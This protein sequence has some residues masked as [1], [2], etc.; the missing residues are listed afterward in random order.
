MMY[1][2]KSLVICSLMVASSIASPKVP[3]T[4]AEELMS[5]SFASQLGL[6]QAWRRQLHVTNGASAIADFQ[7][8]IS[9]SN[10]RKSV[11]VVEVGAEGQDPKVWFSIATDQI[12]KSGQPIGE[13]EAQRLARRQ[14]TFLTR[15]VKNELKIESKETPRVYLYTLASNGTVDCRDAESGKPIWISQV[16]DPELNYGQLGVDDQ[17]VTVL[18]GSSIILLDASNGEPIDSKRT[19]DVPLYGTVISGGFVLAPT[20]RNGVEGY[21]LADLNKKIT[22]VRYMQTVEGLSLEPLA[23]SPTSPVVAWGT[24]KGYIY[25]MDV[26]NAP[27]VTF[28]LDTVGN[29]NGK[30]APAGGDRFFF[31]SEGGQAYSVRATRLG[32]VLWSQPL[33]EPFYDTP[34][35]LE[36]TVF[37][38]S[39][40][41]NLFALNERTG[42]P[43]WAEPTS[44]VAKILGGIPGALF[45]RLMSGQF[46]EIDAKTG[47]VMSVLPIDKSE[48]LAVNR[49]TDRLY[50]IDGR[51]VAQCL[52][53]VGSTAPAILHP[54]DAEPVV[55]EEAESTEKPEEAMPTETTPTDPFGTGGDPFGTGGADPFGTGGGS[56][57]FGTSG[58]GDPFGGDPFGN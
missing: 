4:S 49:L 26:T 30:P 18:N 5:A 42:E 24:N 34:F 56:D 29:V 14:V 15:R 6:E 57:P 37:L 19:I 25:F 50:L 41:G 17:F 58:G 1:R 22:T 13:K 3:T 33:G 55:E 45:V 32:D 36:S 54:L 44:S 40:Y 2:A 35:L 43:I 28:R 27:S 12:D 39:A 16:G 21:R 47:K 7:I 8:Y 9:T 31:A 11:E 52:R 23:K 46:A 20:I 10:P 53:P 48:F 38:N 51:G